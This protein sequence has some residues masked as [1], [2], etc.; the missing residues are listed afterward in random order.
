MTHAVSKRTLALIEQRV[1]ERIPA[2]RAK[3]PHS[4]AGIRTRASIAVWAS[5]ATS[6]VLEGLELA[7]LSL[8]VEEHDLPAHKIAGAAARVQLMHALVAAAGFEI[9]GT[10]PAKVAIR[11]LEEATN[12]AAEEFLEHSQSEQPL[13]ETIETINTALKTKP[14]RKVLRETVPIKRILTLA[15]LPGTAR[16]GLISAKP[17]LLQSALRGELVLGPVNQDWEPDAALNACRSR[18]A[19]TPHASEAVRFRARQSIDHWGRQRKNAPPLAEIWACACAGTMLNSTARWGAAVYAKARAQ[20]HSDAEAYGN[21]IIQHAQHILEETSQ[22][23]R[24]LARIELGALI[25]IGSERAERALRACENAWES[26]PE[27][28]KISDGQLL[29]IHQSKRGALWRVA[30][31]C[32]SALCA[33]TTSTPIWYGNR[34]KELEQQ[35]EIGTYAAQ[36][37]RELLVY[38]ALLMPITPNPQLCIRIAR[39]SGLRTQRPVRDAATA[40]TKAIA[41]ANLDLE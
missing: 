25:G 30:Y 31:N 1:A 34:P 3:C 9:A 38:S 2:L 22:H 4:A 41:E 36:A 7:K 35:M 17:W 14:H 37:G 6:H 40:A 39:T 21:A 18:C 12:Q 13:R 26:S 15:R 11:D 32:A 10:L 20:T 24:T 19:H 8:P 27:L 29:T 23:V 16:N 28:L 33:A 5:Q